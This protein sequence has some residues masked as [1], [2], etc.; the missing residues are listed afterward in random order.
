MILSAMLVALGAFLSGL[1]WLALAVALVRRAKRLTERRLLASVATRRAEFD[2]ER[3]ELR[4]RHAVEMHRQEREVGRVLDL[5]TAYRLEADV[6]DLDVGGLKAEFVAREEEIR[7][8]EARLA[9][10]RELVQELERRHAEAGAALRATQHSLKLERRRRIAAEESLEEAETLAE[11]RRAELMALRAENAALRAGAGDRVPAEFAAAPTDADGAEERPRMPAAAMPIADLGREVE[12]E[13]LRQGASVVP[14]RPRAPAEPVER[15]DALVAQAT[16]NLQRLAGEA[17]GEISHNVWR[18]GGC[19][20]R[21]TNGHENGDFGV[22]ADLEARRAAAMAGE[23]GQVED[24]AARSRFYEALSE[25]RTTKRP[26]IQ[27]GE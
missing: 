18:P 3:D 13:P 7:E 2:A 24:E 22:V 16:R 17:N 12:P 11:E 26:A 10:Q 25:I 20:G 19:E 1:L 5:A 8:T 27:A 15:P 14:L 21:R 4:A 6:K 9:V 23:A